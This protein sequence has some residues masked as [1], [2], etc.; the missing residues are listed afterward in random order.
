M[1]PREQS[2]TG[3]DMLDFAELIHSS[4]GD[5]EPELKR[6]ATALEALV[7]LLEERGELPQPLPRLWT[8]PLK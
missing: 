6:I 8:E 2:D 7:A 1:T 3:L 5:I 4:I